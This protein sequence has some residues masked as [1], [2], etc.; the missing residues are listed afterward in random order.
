MTKKITAV[1]LIATLLPFTKA[2]ANVGNSANVPV[3]GYLYLM[4][5]IGAAYFLFLV[6]RMQ[7]KNLITIN[8]K[9]NNENNN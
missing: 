4:L 2:F 1:M 6:I 9:Q 7:R 3:T 5:S 8:K